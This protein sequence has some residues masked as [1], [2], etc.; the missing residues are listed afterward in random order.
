MTTQW[1]ALSADEISRLSQQGCTCTDW[2]KVQVAEGFRTDRVRMTHFCGEVRL[3][4]FDKEVPFFGGV[5]KPTGISH[6]TI[7]NATIG[8]NVYINAVRNYIANYVIEDEV[9]IDSIDL[10]AVEGESSFAN[11]TKVAVVNKPAGARS[12]ST[13]N[14]RRRPP[15]SW[16][17]TNTGPRSSRSCGPWSTATRRRSGPG[18]AAWARVPG[19]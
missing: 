16:R 19:S 5:T 11:G 1:R 8:D 14:C 6:A 7:H 2:S 17:S 12:R 13:T 4:R 15:M 9:V 3:G 18:W 10:L